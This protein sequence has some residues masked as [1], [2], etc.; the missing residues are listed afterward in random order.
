MSARLGRSLVTALLVLA[1]AVPP[2][3]PAQDA[4]ADGD[5]F[6]VLLAAAEAK[7][8]RGEWSAA[9]DALTELF[10]A[11]AE[12]D[13][14][15]RPQAIVA[16]AHAVQW[17]L[18][19]ARGRYEAVRDAIAT[20]EPSLRDS[21]DAV[22]LRARALLRVGD[23]GAAG[24]LLAALAGR[25]PDD[26]EVRH[27]LAEVR[28]AAGLRAEARALWQANAAAEPK[29]A[30]G[31][32]FRGASL[33]RLGGRANLEAA[34]RA[35]V[36]ALELDPR[37]REARIVLGMCKFAAYGEAAGFPS[38]EKD[39][40]AVLADHVDDEEAL[41]ALYRIRSANMVLDADKTEECLRRALERNERCV[42][43]LVLRAANVLDDR[44]YRDAAR[45]LD[46]VLAIDPND[47]LALCHRA[48]AAW[49]LH[50]E[51]A[52]QSFRA[53]ALAGDPGWHEC[54]RVLAE[55]LSSLYRFADALPFFAAARQAAPDDLPTLQGM[56]KAM[57][58]TGQGEAARE[59]LERS[60][61]VAGGLVDP[62]RNNALAVQQLLDDEYVTV[63]SGPF[64][65]QMHR[66]DGDVLQAYLLPIQLEAAESLGAKYGWRPE[67]RTRIEVLRTWDDFS[68]RTIGFRGFTALGVCFG[69]LITLVSPVDADVRR[70]DFMWEATA[71]HEYA[72][73]LTLGLSDNRVPRW[74]TEGFSVHEERA[75]DPS[76]ERGMDRELFDAFHN[77]DIPPVHLLNRL[78]RG[79]RILFGYY[80][81]G[82][83]VDWIVQ[84]HGFAKAIDLLRA[85]G[86]DLDTE[87]AF[88]KALGMSSQRF[89]ADF[90]RWIEQERLRGMRLVK[91]PDAAA[92]ARLA[93]KAAREPRNVQV[94]VDLA[95][96]CLQRANPVD[97]GRWLAEAFRIDADFAPAELAR[98]EL[99][100][101]RE[102]LD[103]ALAS[104][105]KGFAGGADDFDSRIAHGRALLAAG[106]ADGAI[107]AWQAAKA[108]WPACT[109]V[110]SAPEL[111]LA[112]L[113]RD[114]GDAAAALAET[115]AYC[116]RSA[117]AFAPRYDLA[118]AARAAGDAA[119]AARW[120]FE[121]NRIDP[122][123]RELHVFLGEALATQG[124]TAEAAREFEVAAAVLPEFD[125][126]FAVGGGE[127]PELAADRAERADLWL[128]AARLR[129]GLGD[130]ERA[131][132]LLE[133]IAREA[134]DTPAAQVARDLSAE[135]RRK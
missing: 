110:G 106:D 37:Q 21:R 103:G 122:F 10:D 77:A 15:A 32:A 100:R 118:M 70:N 57:V 22:L 11:L 75:R 36:T 12:A 23:H 56:A 107:A 44:R 28:H 99:L 5:E 91:R 25:L 83:I 116:R 134:D 35:L 60:K 52:Y 102:D 90:L 104:W 6:T 1:A 94:R 62:W 3:L 30:R 120:F 133:R 105:R 40:R 58:C 114:R 85:Y 34:S 31:H 20:A 74:L 26:G 112:R 79:P 80:Q 29:D 128:R 76:W 129:N 96:G 95:W 131:Q 9:E 47:R 125:R 71:W 135:W 7:F 81:G 19:L 126:R 88:A 89:D 8:R 69:R 64:D 66:L 130:G 24:N 67:G 78:F 63:A 16:A 65:V 33:Y 119:E 113:H 41:L 92:M 97:A 84:H 132:A 42:P 108:C 93:T 27:A 61:A 17:R 13:A 87:A 123:H 73:V 38:G 124:R 127:R 14:S 117:R 51:S 43:A 53:R 82:L 121:C 18:D 109:E 45:L 55:H 68:V 54:D 111:L 46:E 49:L 39:L 4:E 2:V 48:A 101:R 86:E 115:K 72:H 50:D 98:A 59:L